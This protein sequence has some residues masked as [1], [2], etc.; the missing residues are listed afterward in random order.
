MV[1]HN[2]AKVGVAGST[3]VSR[4]IFFILLFSI[5]LLAQ[6]IQIKPS[7]TIQKPCISPSTFDINNSQTC[8]I[9]LSKHRS[10]WQIPIF[11]IKEYLSALGITHVQSQAKV[12][13]FK[14]QTPKEYPN[15]KKLLKQRYLQHYPTLTISN[16][17]IKPTSTRAN[18]FSY[19][20]SCQ[21]SLPQRALRKNQG[22]FVLKCGKMRHFFQYRING[23]IG[24]YKA[25]HQ[26]KKDRII[27]LKDVK[28]AIIPFETF[29]ALPIT[30]TKIGEVIARQHIPKGK[31]I[32]E[33]MVTAIP[34]VFKHHPVRCFY[35]DGAVHIEF[36]GKALQNGFIGETILIK[37]SD[38]KALRGRVVDKNMVEIQ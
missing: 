2:L 23:T 29:Y 26:I 38:G 33:M 12:I 6:T 27:T 4:S 21:L 1:E 28:P 17:E 24:V 7:Y 20:P 36:E 8:I 30:Q 13:Q 19:I 35:N 32:T 9:P 31:V 15:L 37:K 5:Q 18:S 3:P 11:K 16:I 14:L 25:N 34:A 10:K 22:S